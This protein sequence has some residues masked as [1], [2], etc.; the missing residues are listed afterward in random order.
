MLFLEDKGLP[1][2]PYKTESLYIFS[3]VF[4]AE[5]TIKRV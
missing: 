4:L 3:F 5:G 1:S 2:A